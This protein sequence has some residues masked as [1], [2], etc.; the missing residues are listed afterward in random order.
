MRLPDPAPAPARDYPA[1]GGVLR[2]EIPLPGGR[3]AP[4][5]APDW[6]FRIADPPVDRHADELLGRERLTPEV[7]VALYRRPDGGL[8]LSYTG[9][10]IGD[11][12]V[13]SDGSRI[14]WTPGANPP[15][16]RIGWILLGRVMAL[17]HHLAG[18]L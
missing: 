9:H 15:L 2:S 11:F 16:E 17:S 3:C 14:S 12:L 6:T 18:T 8:R 13:S 10:D 5:G 1:Y 7:C 4:A